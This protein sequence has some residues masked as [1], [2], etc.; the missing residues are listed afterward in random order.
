MRGAQTDASYRFR[1]GNV[2]AISRPCPPAPLGRWRLQVVFRSP[3][4]VL[5]TVAE[6]AA[7]AEA[8]R[9]EY[10]EA[11]RDADRN[12][13]AGLWARALGE[14][15]ALAAIRDRLSAYFTLRNLADPHDEDTEDL[16]ARTED[17]RGR[18]GRD[19]S[20]FFR[21]WRA[22]DEGRRL[23]LLGDGALSDWE[24]ALIG[25][26]DSAAQRADER[27]RVA[28]EWRNESAATGWRRLHRETISGL[29]FDIPGD[30]EP[31]RMGIAERRAL[32]RSAD[33]AQRRAYIDGLYGAA[34][35]H[36]GTFA[37]CYDNLVA[38]RLATDSYYG[39]GEAHERA[40]EADRLPARFTE[41]ILGLVRGHYELHRRW[42]RVRA[43]LD[44]QKSLSGYD[45]YAPALT[46]AP[47]ITYEET[48][49]LLSDALGAFPAQ[50]GAY[51]RRLFSGGHVDAQPD[52]RK[53]GTI[54]CLQVAPGVAPFITMTYLD[55]MDAALTLAHEV[56]H[57]LHRGL[58]GETWGALRTRTG[59]TI[60]EVAA[61]FADHLMHDQLDVRLGGDEET[62]LRL[63]V[64]R[65]GSVFDSLTTQ[66]CMA[67]FERDAYALR[68]A[69]RRLTAERLTE[70]W[71]RHTAEQYGQDLVPFPGAE[72]HWSLVPHFIDRRLHT[73][74]YVIAEL[75]ASALVAQHREDPEAAGRRV[76]EELLMSGGARSPERIFAGLGLD[77]DS[78][79]TWEG[80]LALIEH[81]LAELE[82][83][84][85]TR[86][87]TPSAA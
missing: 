40:A 31:R 65:L 53:G 79:E 67:L 2:S 13:D 68:A 41:D 45:L 77:L 38:D 83:A 71:V 60:T 78:M 58:S 86:T 81:D 19:V 64:D 4:E 84:V 25:L 28:L 70:L 75:A 46:P 18:A 80:G 73:S 57:A 34:E 82:A 15:D 85:T 21:V 12:A 32:I 11:L 61:V 44:E 33:P 74:S 59:P 37:A 62:R 8:F 42:V 69:G 5:R 55:G 54:G 36:V 20:C 6:Y 56:G 26:T 7:A 87:S 29:R 35:P 47:A 50:V 51:L 3:E 63:R 39:Y 23:A 9:T 14:L 76:T 52:A 17:E 22:L 30:G 43:A 16:F 27:R 66:T 10:D 1:M 49:G 48:Q 72:R 24:H